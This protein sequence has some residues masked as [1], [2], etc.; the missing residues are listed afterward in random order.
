[1]LIS[2]KTLKL[3]I[4]C[5]TVCI[6]TQIKMDEESP[7]K[8]H[9]VIN[10]KEFELLIIATIQTLKRS[11]KKTG[12]EEVFNLVQS[13]LE[14]DVSREQLDETLTTFVKDNSIK[15]NTV[16]NRVCLPLPKDQQENNMEPQANTLTSANNMKDEFDKFKE[17]FMK[18]FKE[19]KT[20]LFA[21]VNSFKNQ[22][23]TSHKILQSIFQNSETTEMIRL[24]EDI[25]FLKEQIRNKDKV[26]D[27]LLCQLS[28]R[29]DIFSLQNT[30]STKTKT[31][32]VQTENIEN[33]AEKNLQLP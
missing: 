17:G 20:T 7:Q 27:S 14:Y 31:S 6:H 23:L 32:A 29:D 10:N 33:T 13:S 28:K 1:M 19:L 2:V 9:G 5:Y 18:E 24:R 21:E 8:N 3:Q 26:I 16:G 25:L 12:N 11:K 15:S 4:R 22:I 30:G